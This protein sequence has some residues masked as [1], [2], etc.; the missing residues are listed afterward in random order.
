MC[1]S[2]ITGLMSPSRTIMRVASGKKATDTGPMTFRNTVD[3]GNVLGINPKKPAQDT[4][5]AELEAQRQARITKNVSDINSA[6][7]GRE[8]QYADFAKALQTKYTGDLSRQYADAN[9]NLKF[10][11]AGSGLTGGSVAADKGRDLGRE[12]AEGTTAVQSKVNQAEAGL[13]SQ[14]E[15]A[16]TQLIA[17][18]QAGGDI[19]NAAGQTSSMLQANL[20]GANGAAASLGDIFGSTAATYKTLQEARN[21][22]RGLTSSYEQVYGSGIGRPGV[23]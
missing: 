21:L 1:F 18:A 16:R 17:L 14:D 8:R 7:A 19:G 12:M 6:Y 20:Q 9:R 4:S 2:K 5:A 10:E 15:N 23:R 11:L 22:R 3:E 13:R